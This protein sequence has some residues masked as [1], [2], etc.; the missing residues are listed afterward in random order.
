MK[1]EKFMNGSIMRRMTEEAAVFWYRENISVSLLDKA[2]S[3]YCG[4]RHL[5]S[6]GY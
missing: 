3:G 5:I 4:N 2:A 1:Q 6:D